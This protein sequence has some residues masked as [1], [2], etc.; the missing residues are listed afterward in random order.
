MRETPTDPRREHILDAARRLFAEHGPQKTTV[1]DIAR[2][3]GVGVGTV[4][5]EFDSKDAI[6]SELSGTMHGVVLAA[7]QEALRA[8]DADAD[9]STAFV[10]VIEAR[11]RAFLSFREKGPGGKTCELL[12]CRTEVTRREQARFFE[13]ERAF[14]TELFAVAGR[15]RELGPHDAGRVAELVQL[16][17][18]SLSPPTLFILPPADA[19]A[20]ARDLA[21]LLVVGLASRG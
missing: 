17:L 7:M 2:A 8:R 14:Y 1:A 19:A 9:L 11:T 4:Y 5:L 15:R 16:A 18:A 20:R 21:V 10:A 13:R 3:A 6:V 12:Q